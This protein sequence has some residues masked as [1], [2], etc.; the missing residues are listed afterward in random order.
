MRAKPASA[1]PMWD[2]SLRS[3]RRMR[4]SNKYANAR[5]ANA[6]AMLTGGDDRPRKGGEANGVGKGR[7]AIPV[8]KWG[9]A[10]ARNAPP[11]KNA[12]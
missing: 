11:K 6:H 3:I 4:A 9:T 7:R 5:F 8:R 10:F 1:G 2:H 12:R